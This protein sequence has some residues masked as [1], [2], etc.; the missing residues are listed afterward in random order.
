MLDS[1][2]APDIS[3]GSSAADEAGLEVGW[4]NAAG[5]TR[6][7]CESEGEDYTDIPSE[8]P[9]RPWSPTKRLLAAI[10]YQAFVD[11]RSTAQ[12]QRRDASDWFGLP[13]E[14]VA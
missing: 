14:N 12:P 2:M 13:Q 8:E 10:L 9:D 7:R 11:V 6:D 4:S 1:P 5:E 3:E